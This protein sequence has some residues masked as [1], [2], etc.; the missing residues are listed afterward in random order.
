MIRIPRRLSASLLAFCLTAGLLSGCSGGGNKDA[1]SAAAG[2]QG[3][4]LYASATA[5]EGGDGSRAAPFNSLQALELASEPG[6]T[7]VILPSPVEAP[8]LDGGIGLKP[9]QRLIGGG[10]DVLQP[11]GQARLPRIRNSSIA[12]FNGDAVRLAPNSRVE[13]LVISGAVRG[14]VYGQNVPGATVVGNDISG[15]NTSCMIGFTVEPFPAPSSYPMGAVPLL[16]PA[17]WAAIMIDANTGA[18]SIE[19][20]GNYVHDNACGN[21]IDVRMSGDADYTAEISQNFITHLEHGPLHQTEEIHLVHAITLQSTD[22]ARLEAESTHNTQTYI[23]SPH[24]DCEGL[25]LNIADSGTAIWNVEHNYF[26]HGIG[27]F[28]CNGMEFIISNGNGYGEM[29]I[30]NSHF[31]DNPGDM[32]EQANLGSGS[33]AILELDH[34][35]AKDTHERGGDPAQGPLPFNIGECLLTGSTGTNNRT[36]LKISNTE[37]SGCNNGLSVLSGA[38][39]TTN[40]L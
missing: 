32:L 26:A 38:N 29:S 20:S 21:G 30:R 36:I 2:A 7:L 40:L 10:P 37:F 9:G 13:N 5:A 34:V 4:S 39:L 31:E 11:A 3:R 24:A 12:R 6:D 27:G 18:G 15:F 8:A 1:G 33:T 14:A 35:V 23:G 19:I 17:G 28:S 16:L 25:F 22:T